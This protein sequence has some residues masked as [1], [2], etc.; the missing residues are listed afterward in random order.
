[1]E[2]SCGALQ[3][4]VEEICTTKYFSKILA[5]NVGNRMSLSLKLKELEVPT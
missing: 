5:R 1:M 4:Y 2:N 3:K